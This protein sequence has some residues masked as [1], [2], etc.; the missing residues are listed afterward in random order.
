MRTTVTGDS[1]TVEKGPIRYPK[2][3]QT[4]HAAWPYIREGSNITTNGG[5]WRII[6]K[7][8]WNSYNIVYAIISYKYKD[9]TAR[10][11]HFISLGNITVDLSISAI[12]QVKKNIIFYRRG[13]DPKI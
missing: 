1:Q 8:D 9:T 2:R 5:Q 6:K 10:G 11:P 3:N 7:V 13:T 4:D 12:K